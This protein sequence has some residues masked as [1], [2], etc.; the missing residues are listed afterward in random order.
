MVEIVAPPFRASLLEP[1]ATSSLPFW[2]AFWASACAAFSAFS[3][4]WSGYIDKI[5]RC[6]LTIEK[7]GLGLIDSIS[8]KIKLDKPILG[9]HIKK[10]TVF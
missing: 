10:V 5:K 9:T 1:W 2:V 6:K 8:I 7:V 3:A 4:N